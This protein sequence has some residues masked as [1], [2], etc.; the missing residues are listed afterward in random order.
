ME[1]VNWCTDKPLQ[2]IKG[3]VNLFIILDVIVTKY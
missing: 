2:V 3:L 1:G